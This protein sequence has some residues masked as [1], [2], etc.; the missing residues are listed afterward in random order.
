MKQ[1]KEKKVGEYISTSVSLAIAVNLRNK[2]FNDAIRLENF[3]WSFMFKKRLKLKRYPISS[4]SILLSSVDAVITLQVAQIL[5]NLHTLL[6]FS[7]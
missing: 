4:R 3:P 1:K 5:C 6:A 2:S 7:T